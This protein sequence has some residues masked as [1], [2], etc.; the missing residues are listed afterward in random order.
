MKSG[1]G[2][3][4]A[5]G[6]VSGGRPERRSAHASTTALRGQLQKG[7]SVAGGENAPVTPVGGKWRGVMALRVRELGTDR[8]SRQPGPSSGN[9]QSLM[10]L[11]VR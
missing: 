10:S 3:L 2:G 4:S 6:P 9:T 5:V 1:S 8:Y 11:I 7:S